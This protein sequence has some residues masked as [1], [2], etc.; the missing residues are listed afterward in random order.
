MSSNPVI[1]VEGML[2]EAMSELSESL[3]SRSTLST[4]AV[5]EYG[6]SMS[7]QLDGGAKVQSWVELEE[8]LDVGITCG[9]AAVFG[10]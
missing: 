3:S 6:S 7:V 4:S 9:F 10:G 2:Q 5:S 8:S 1:S